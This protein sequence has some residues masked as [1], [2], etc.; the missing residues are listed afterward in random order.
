MWP[1]VRITDT[2]AT[3]S[4][5]LATD[6]VDL[7]AEEI[8]SL[9]SLAATVPTRDDLVVVAE[10]RVLTARRRQVTSE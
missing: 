5:I 9:S 1:T 10:R 2:L 4:G 3:L 6:G 8:N 7:N